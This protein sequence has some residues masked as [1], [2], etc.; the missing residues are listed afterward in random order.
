LV[1]LAAESTFLFLMLRS[2]LKFQTYVYFTQF[3]RQLH[4]W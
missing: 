2:G 3:T 4:Y 1:G